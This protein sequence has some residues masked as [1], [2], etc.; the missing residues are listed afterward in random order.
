M[1]SRRILA[2][3]LAAAVSLISG[4]AKAWGP[5]SQVAIVSA[6]TRLLGQDSA[7]NLHQ[8]LRYV[9]QGASMAPDRQKALYASFDVDPV[10]AIQRE[11]ILMASVR[12]DRIDPYYAYR[13]GGLG[14]LVAQATAPFAVDDTGSVRARYYADVDAAIDRTNLTPTPRRVVDPRAYFSMLRTDTAA[15][16]QTIVVDYRG[17]LG[18]NGFARASLPQDASRSVNAVADVWYTVLTSQ[19]PLYDQ[20]VTAKRDFVLDSLDFYLAMGNLEEA[21]ATY[22]SAQAM[23]ILD[24]NLRKAIGDRY[25]AAEHY[26]RA[27]VEYL[28]ILESTP[29]RRDV[30]ERVAEFYEQEGDRKEEAG[31]LEGA[32]EAYSKAVGANSLLTD[33][34]RKL[35]DVDSRIA[36]RDQRLLVQRGAADEARELENQSEEA[37]MRRDYARAIALLRDAEARYSS[38][39]EEFPEESKIASV[40]LRNV[41]LRLKEL[42]QELITN[43]R[44]LSGT[45]YMYDVQQI[46]VKTPDGSAQALESMLQR[47]FSGAV[48][49]L[50]QQVTPE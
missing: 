14:K 28:K 30:V 42:K 1:R 31:D 4:G 26:E 25:F 39:T 6:G 18:F 22:E 23:G 33:A 40:G 2:A 8:M 29:D 15:N 27:M 37:A 17:G 44:T 35:L 24:D 11:M 3:V 41:T 21:K 47:E 9:V 50:G 43:S 48:A 10:A 13:L 45:G 19:M 32:R 34:Q 5:E 46:A 7:F 49:A 20:P 16:E 38:V 12:G 36:D